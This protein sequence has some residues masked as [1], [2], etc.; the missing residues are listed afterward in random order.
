MK[1][2]LCCFFSVAV[3]YDLF[4]RSAYQILR[5]YGKNERKIKIQDGIRMKRNNARVGNCN[6][7]K[8]KKK[9]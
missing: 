2:K 7:I 5:C 6:L 8:R 1:R 9:V 4:S 3:A